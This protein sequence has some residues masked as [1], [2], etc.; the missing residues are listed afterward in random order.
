M[1]KEE[2]NLYET[3]SEFM[4]RYE[5]F[6]KEEVVNEKDQQLPEKTRYMAILAVLLGCQGIDEFKEQLPAALEAGLT[7]VQIKEIVYQATDYLGMGRVRPF[8]SVTNEVF[9]EKGVKLPLEGQCTTTMDNRLEKGIE[10]QVEIFG[11]H[12]NETWKA[13]HMNRWLAANCFGDYY[14]RKGLDLKEREM[15]TFCYL[16]AQGGC[17]P[18]V[19]AHAKGNMNLGNDKDFLVRVV[20]QCLPYIGYPRSLNAISCI[21][22]AA[23]E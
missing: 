10:A 14:T 21:Q 3:D 1:L 6:A 4:E 12:M 15:V 17:E 23:E 11:E 22:K 13:G 9:Q 19:I 8:L 16:I 5:Y 2:S 7:P 20:S 18:Q